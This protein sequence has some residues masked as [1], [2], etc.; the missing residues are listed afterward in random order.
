MKHYVSIQE[1]TAVFT[2]MA[3]VAL[4][5]AA[6]FVEPRG[7]IHSSVCWVFAQ[8]LIYAGSLFGVAQYVRA[9]VGKAG[10]ASPG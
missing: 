7:Q 6:L 4:A 10:A 1:G 3:G 8:C 2:V 9:Q 5:F